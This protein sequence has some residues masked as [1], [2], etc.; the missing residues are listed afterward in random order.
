[1]QDG[2]F[3]FL[4]VFSISL[5]LMETIPKSDCRKIGFIRK[6]HGVHGELV[7][8]Y[9]PEF[10]DS[11][12]EATR[13]FLEIDGLL[14]PFFVAE[15]GFRFKSSDTALIIFDWIETENRARELVG[16]SVY[17]FNNELI[18]NEEELPASQLINFRLLNEE[19]QEVG[20]I[21]AV[22]DYSGNMVFTLDSNGDEILVPYHD[23]LL[24]NLDNNRKTIQLILPEGL[25]D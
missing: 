22:D 2:F 13:F 18:E 15:N 25:L 24:I 8:E 23:E 4:K 17:L 5:L 16:S 19:G 20:I 14:V 9:E 7:L 1:M 12:A 11:V 6:T 21:T 10:E 3:M